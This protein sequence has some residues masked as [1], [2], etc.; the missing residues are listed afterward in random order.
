VSHIGKNSADGLDFTMIGAGTAIH[1]KILAVGTHDQPIEHVIESGSAARVRLSLG[2]QRPGSATAAIG[3]TLNEAR[4]GE[5]GIEGKIAQHIE[6]SI[7]ANRKALDAAGK[8]VIRRAIQLRAG[9]AVARLQINPVDVSVNF[10]EI[11]LVI[12]WI[13]CQPDI[14]AV[15][16][17]VQHQANL[18]VGIEG[19]GCRLYCNARQ[20]T[21]GDRAEPKHKTEAELHSK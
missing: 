17:G 10:E 16:G 18:Q 6:G 11:K 7:W 1:V 9:R 14:L 19:D 4:I 5:V 3:H 8:T 2:E 21:G 12:S 20:K 13:L 15:V